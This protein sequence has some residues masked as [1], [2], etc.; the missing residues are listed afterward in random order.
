MDN[1][2]V[3]YSGRGNR[4]KSYIIPEISALSNTTS[5]E[6]LVGHTGDDTNPLKVVAEKETEKF[7]PL[8]YRASHPIVLSA[9][10]IGNADRYYEVYEG[11][12]NVTEGELLMKLKVQKQY[13]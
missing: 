5:R 10:V 2:F 8:A 11:I 13:G 1:Y 3:S 7:L 4:V 9:Y 6:N 12:Y